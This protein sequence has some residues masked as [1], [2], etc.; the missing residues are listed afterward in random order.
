MLGLC[1]MKFSLL[2]RAHLCAPSSLPVE[3]QPAVLPGNRIRSSV[4]LSAS[5]RSTTTCVSEHFVTFA[6]RENVLYLMALGPP[7]TVKPH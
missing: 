6:V 2:W 4:A 3:V 7:I 5:P 1:R